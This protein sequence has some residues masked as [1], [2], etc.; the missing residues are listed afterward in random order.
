MGVVVH[1]SSRHLGDFD[2]ALSGQLRYRFVVAS[3]LGR[4]FFYVPVS[5]RAQAGTVFRLMLLGRLHVE[6]GAMSCVAFCTG[7]FRARRARSVWL[8]L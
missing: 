7:V 5:V 6:S 1:H 8:R 4:P 2:R 3:I